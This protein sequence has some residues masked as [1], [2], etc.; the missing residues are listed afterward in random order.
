MKNW[1][2][3]IHDVVGGRWIGVVQGRDEQE[4]RHAALSRFDIPAE[5]DFDV[6]PRRFPL[7]PSLS[8]LRRRRR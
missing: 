8:P 4:A 3:R 5:A 1:N 2:V 7:V 6:S